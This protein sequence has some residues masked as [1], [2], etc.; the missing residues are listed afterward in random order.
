MSLA[1]TKGGEIPP[2]EKLVSFMSTLSEYLASN[3]AGLLRAQ[4]ERFRGLLAMFNVS[5]TQLVEPLVFESMDPNT[6]IEIPWWRNSLMRRQFMWN[7][8]MAVSFV[9]IKVE[10]LN[11]LVCECL[12]VL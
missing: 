5:M 2:L 1:I 8:E 11:V 4:S 6:S 7:E 3:P 10:L 9:S 12:F